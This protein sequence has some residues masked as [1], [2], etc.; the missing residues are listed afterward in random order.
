MNWYKIFYWITVAD[1]V[2]SLFNTFGVILTIISIITLIVMVV[3]MINL[4]DYQSNNR[5]GKD[6]EKSMKYWLTAFRRLFIWSF[7]I[8]MFCWA[9][10][11]FTPSKKDCLLIVAG[12]SVGTFIQSDSSSQQIPGDITRFLH[13]SLQKEISDLGDETK[14]ELGVQTPKERLIDNVEEMTKEEIINFLK[15]DTTISI[16]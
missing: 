12:G 2:K 4:G 5:V 14:K 9:G 16:K 1:S 10:F 13:L 8:S 15:E 7:V 6:E 3:M 11:V